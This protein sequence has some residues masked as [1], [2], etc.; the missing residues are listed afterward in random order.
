MMPTSM[1]EFANMIRPAT[2]KRTHRLRRPTGP[3][4]PFDMMDRFGLGTEP[5]VPPVKRATA[6][7][8]LSWS[9]AGSSLISGRVE[10]RDQSPGAG[11][12]TGPDTGA[13]QSARR[14]GP[15]GTA[16]H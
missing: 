8:N 11:P 16:E 5:I 10:N 3:A 14:I 13:R 1:I 6:G 9:G 15:A 12:V 4:G 7:P 2:P